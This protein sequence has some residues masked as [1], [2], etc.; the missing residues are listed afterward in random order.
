MRL[1]YDDKIVIFARAISL[2]LFSIAHE[3]ETF[4]PHLHSDIA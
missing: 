1:I 4:S 2:S 3:F